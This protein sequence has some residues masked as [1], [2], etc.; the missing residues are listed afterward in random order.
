MT[1]EDVEIL[2]GL[3]RRNG[4]QRLHEVILGAGPIQAQLH[5]LAEGNG[6]A[7]VV[8]RERS[9]FAEPLLPMHHLRRE[10]CV[11]RRDTGWVQAVEPEANWD[12]WWQREVMAG[13]EVFRRAVAV[14]SCHG[15]TSRP[16]WN[17]RVAVNGTIAHVAEAFAQ[18]SAPP[19]EQADAILMGIEGVRELLEEVDDV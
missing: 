8:E 6:V 19:F 11:V 9:P 4:R 2:A 14:L 15:P 10:R 17:L 5:K 13:V 7:R 1:D 3:I 12:G 18:Q 16:L